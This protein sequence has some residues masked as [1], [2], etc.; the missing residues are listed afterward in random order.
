MR[1][2]TMNRRLFLKVSGLAASAALAAACAA[3]PSEPAQVEVQA[4]DTPAPESA[5][6]T[7][8]EPATA[9]ASVSKYREAPMLAEKVAAGELPP[10]EERLPK[11]PLVQP[12][13]E[14]IGE[15]GGTW[16]RAAVSVSDTSL[17][18]RLYPDALIYFSIDGNTLEPAVAKSWEAS[19]DG[20][21][22]TFHLREGMKWSDGAPYTADDIMFWWEDVVGNEELS[23]I[24][25]AWMRVAGEYGTVEKIDDYTVKFSFPQP[26]GTFLEWLAT[27]QFHGVPKHYMQQFHIKY[28]DQAELEKETADASFDHWYQ[29]FGNRNNPYNNPDR[30][31]LGAWQFVTQPDQNPL[32]AE[33]NPYYYRVDPEGN[34]LPYID[35]VQFD[36][37]TNVEVLNFM[38]IAGELDC[39]SRQINL[40]NYPLFVE[41]QEQGDYRIIEWPGDGGSDA[42][43]I[44]NMNSGQQEGASEHQKVVGDLLRTLELR[45]ALSI[46]IDRDEIWNSAFLGFGEPRQ[47]APMQWSPY[48]EEGMETP[49]I[50]FDPERA[51]QML[52][53]LG[54]DQRDS[55]GFRLGP[56]GQPV[57]LT[58]AA[59]DLFG[60]WVDTA[61][62][63]NN[64]WNAVGLKCV[65]SVEER[66]LYTTRQQAGEHQVDVWNS[67]GNG[68]VLIYPYWVMPYSAASQMAPLSGNWYESGGQSG[69]EPTGDLRRVIDLF[70]QAQVTPDEAERTELAKE[71][72]RVNLANLWTIGTIGGT[73]LEMGVVV[74][75]NNFRNV[76]E[77]TP[78]R[79]V[80]N[81]DS[82]HTP[83]NCIPAQYFMRQS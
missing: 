37:V 65:V 38:A 21:E 39:Q 6:T 51:S 24:K 82:V 73:P 78:E 12:V 15:Y 20:R 7:A 58:I 16:H 3:T 66:S 27:V 32:V 13:V 61:Q 59:V 64:H 67:G 33:R 35:R 47:M 48:Y 8:P 18:Y 83:A 49:F 68:K 14:E 54:L 71:I 44:I 77:S 70:D 57:D 25:P 79:H 55:D 45:Q 53:D 34:Q 81:E 2:A 11:E 1:N 43:I 36:L 80:H 50:E 5:P 69:I 4:T 75:K 26:Y 46:A 22:Y 31:V 10:V 72:F 74:T 30:P 60:P 56:D 19:P 63:V 62:L 52:D 17:F 41:G 29:L 28:R 23:P 76:P 9:P 40:V 42:G